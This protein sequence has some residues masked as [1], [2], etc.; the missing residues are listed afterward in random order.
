MTQPALDF[1]PQPKNFTERVIALLESKR[2]QWVDGQ[3]IAEVGGCYA[4]RSRLSDARKPP[5]NRVI[6]NRQRHLVSMTGKKFT[7]SEYRLV[8]P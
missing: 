5:Y 6:E 3:D 2:G 4:W 1:A 8:M 7:V